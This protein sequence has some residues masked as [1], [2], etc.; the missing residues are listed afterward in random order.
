MSPQE[1]REIT[2]Q[3]W[4]IVAALQGPQAILEKEGGGAK[5][6][7]MARVAGLARLG[8]QEMQAKTVSQ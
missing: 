5:E 8:C 4:T 7:G 2:L 1:S 6:G 3:C